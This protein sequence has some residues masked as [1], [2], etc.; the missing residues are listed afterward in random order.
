MLLENTCCM[1][2]GLMDIY[3]GTFRF[4]R[5]AIAIHTSGEHPEKIFVQVSTGPMYKPFSYKF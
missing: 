4:L 2:A 3:N 1:I 5:G